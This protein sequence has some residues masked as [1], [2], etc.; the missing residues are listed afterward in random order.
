MRK[1]FEKRAAFLNE[2]NSVVLSVPENH[3]QF[4]EET[5][6]RVKRLKL[7]QLSEIKL[8]NLSNYQRKLI[9]HNIKPKYADSLYF[10]TIVVSDEEPED[11]ST[12]GRAGKSEEDKS[13]TKGNNNNNKAESPGE[14]DIKKD[15]NPTVQS[16][17]RVL[18]I[19]KLTPE[20]QAAREVEKKQIEMDN[21][22]K[23]VGFSKVI[24]KISQSNKLVVGHNML[25]DVAHTV[26]QF[27]D[28]LPPTL[29][30]FKILVQST[31]PNLVDTKL[32]ASSHP[33]REFI[34]ST[35][36]YD[37]LKRVHSTPFS[38]PGMLSRTWK[39]I[40]GINN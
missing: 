36:L 1:G 2:E 12:D 33:F 16:K 8:N 35:V 24:R 22:T 29:A 26:H 38:M 13:E 23:N 7:S 17:N 21:I 6:E 27:I 15:Q 28:E 39:T 34:N 4:M 25:L 9:F 20:E 14:N 19:A 31:F 10:E 11:M 30:D 37:L 40:G 32:M 5:E 3:R 18:R